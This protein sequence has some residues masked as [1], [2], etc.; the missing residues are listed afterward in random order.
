MSVPAVWCAAFALLVS[1]ASAAPAQQPSK[2]ERF[3]AIAVLPM[4]AGSPT[5]IEIVVERWSTDAEN[6]SVLTGLKELGTKGMLNALLKLK[7]VGSI[8]ASG[9]AGYPLRYAWKNT[10]QDGMERITL[11]TDRPVSFWEASNQFQSLDYPLT[12]IELRMKPG[13]AGTGSG[14]IALAAQMH[15]DRVTNSIVLEDLGLSLVPLSSVKR[16]R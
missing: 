6:E 7:P 3:T 9:S 11:A 1:A 2:P 8:A 5:P 4:E 15:F 12:M 16:L 14:Q 10:G 13:I